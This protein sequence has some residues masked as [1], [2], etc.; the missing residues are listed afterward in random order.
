MEDCCHSKSDE[1]AV[2][3]TTHRRVLWLVLVINFAMFV[4]EF[5]FSWVA[6]SS[7]LL[8]DS[9]DM[10]GD[11]L[12]YGFSLFVIGKSKRW[13][14]SVAV[15]KGSL[16]GILGIGVVGQVIYRFITPTAPVAETMGWIA[17]LALAANLASAML[18]LRH[19]NDDL[20]MRST[21]ICTRNDV[22]SNIAVLV[23]AGLVALTQSKYP[24]L[25]VG[26]GIAGLIL[27]SSYE[28]LVESLAQLRT[29][30][31]QS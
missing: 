29:V 10:L 6:H 28:I 11:A 15:F 22:I 7:S 31:V 8:A 3:A 2:I 24:D 17:G 26:L 16:M 18:L 21:W 1:M 30:E 12:V 14:A 20:N 27:K 9:L 4:V 13:N 19:R 23:T 5:G 25:I